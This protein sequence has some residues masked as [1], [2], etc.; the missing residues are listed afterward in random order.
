MK[1]VSRQ[2]SGIFFFIFEECSD[3]HLV[4]NQLWAWKQMGDQTPLRDCLHYTWQGK[5]C[6]WNIAWDTTAHLSG[7]NVC[8][9]SESIWPQMHSDVIFLLLD[10][11]V[12]GTYAFM[13]VFI[14]VLVPMCAHACT[15]QRW[16]LSIFFELRSTVY[17]EARSL[18]WTQS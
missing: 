14:C 9:W 10:A 16:T 4:K 12:C 8:V 3:K 7:F 17:S 18:T 2:L 6:W 11:Y 15:S 13:N 5:H 1:D